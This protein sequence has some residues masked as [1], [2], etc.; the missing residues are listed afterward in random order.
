MVGCFGNDMRFSIF[1]LGCDYSRRFPLRRELM[2]MPP[3]STLSFLS[4]P[5]FLQQEVVSAPFT[6]QSVRRAHGLRSAAHSTLFTQPPT[7]LSP[8]VSP[9]AC[10]RCIY[11]YVKQVLFCVSIVTWGWP[12]ALFLCLFSIASKKVIDM[13]F[14]SEKVTKFDSCKNS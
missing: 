10:I 3:G 14:Y 11:V 5:L 9:S 6:H 2:T 4:L 13:T 8:Q 12:I 7:A 1:H